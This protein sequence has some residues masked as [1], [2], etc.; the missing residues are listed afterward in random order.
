MVLLLVSRWNHWQKTPFP[1]NTWVR[2]KCN[3]HF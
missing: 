1:S 2:R 3:F